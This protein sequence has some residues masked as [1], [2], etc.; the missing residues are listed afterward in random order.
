MLCTYSVHDKST[1]KLCLFCICILYVLTY[2]HTYVVQTTGDA[3]QET[4]EHYVAE[5]FGEYMVKK[6]FN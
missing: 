5:D 1:Y 4:Q 6:D 3:Q 2:I